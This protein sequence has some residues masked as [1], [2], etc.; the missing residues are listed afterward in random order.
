MIKSLLIDIDETLLHS[1][2]ANN[3]G[4]LMQILPAAAEHFGMKRAEAERRVTWVKENISWWCWGDFIKKLEMNPAQFWEY[5]YHSE[6]AYLEPAEPEL[7]GT[8]SQLAEAGL[9]LYVTSN[10][11]EDGI[12]HK[13]RLAGIPSGKINTFFSGIFGATEMQARKLE[14]TYWRKV[15]AAIGDPPET[16]AVVGD[17]FIDDCITPAMAGLKHFFLLNRN[18]ENDKAVM[19][20]MKLIM[21]ISELSEIIENARCQY[22]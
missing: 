17:S 20:G 19:D 6:S 7:A 15:V 1:R 21:S 10:N 5:A 16:M 18:G 11:P 13:L 14:K 2:Y 4:S 3:T 22:A 8:L 12:R 9:K